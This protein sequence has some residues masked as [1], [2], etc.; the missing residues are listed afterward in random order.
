MGEGPTK[1]VIFEGRL[2]LEGGERLSLGVAGEEAG[3]RK[4]SECKGPG[5]GVGEGTDGMCAE[6]PGECRESQ[7]LLGHGKAFKFYSD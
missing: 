3:S 5:A 6:E 2:K 7:G 4:N 1:E